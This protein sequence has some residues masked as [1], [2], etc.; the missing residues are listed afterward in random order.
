MKTIQ[1]LN[2]DLIRPKLLSFT[3]LSADKEWWCTASVLTAPDSLC[4]SPG[5]LLSPETL[6][7]LISLT[8]ITV[9]MECGEKT[10]GFKIK[11]NS[12]PL[13]RTALSSC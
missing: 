11:S 6:N 10:I 5:W 3:N 7:K 8:T 1:K 4:L 12:Y 2:N 9:L 13:Q